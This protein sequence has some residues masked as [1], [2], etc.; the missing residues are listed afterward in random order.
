M[1]LQWVKEHPAKW[2]AD[3]QRIIGLNHGAESLLQIR[4]K[5]ALR[6]SLESV[7][8]GDAPEVFEAIDTGQPQKMLT[9]TGR[10]LHLQVTP[11][12]TNKATARQRR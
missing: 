1:G 10:F 6:A 2:D 4:E 7:F 3:K 9:T 12:S 8:G 5:D 11:I